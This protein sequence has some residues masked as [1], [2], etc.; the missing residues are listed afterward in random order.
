MLVCA[1]HFK[2]RMRGLPP[3]TG[4]NLPP[5][6]APPFPKASLILYCLAYHAVSIRGVVRIDVAGEQAPSLGKRSGFRNDAGATEGM[7]LRH[8]QA[9]SL[10]E[11]RKQGE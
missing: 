1:Q 10:I 6:A 5:H 3:F 4:S 2:H 9:P 11:G 7:A 8:G